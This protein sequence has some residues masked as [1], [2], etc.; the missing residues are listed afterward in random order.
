MAGLEGT[1]K[2]PGA[3][4]VPKKT[5]AIAGGVAAAVVGVGY[6]RKKKAD[7]AA[8]AAA[9]SDGTLTEGT[10]AL[11][12]TSP[13]GPGDLSGGG[14]VTTGGDPVPAPINLQNP[15]IITNSDWQSA[16]AA[17]DLGG[18]DSSTIT[19]AVSKILGG[20]AVTQDQAEIFQEVAGIIGYPPQGYPP[21][22]LVTTTP[23][24]PPP[25]TNPP[26]SK[27]P[28]KITNTYTAH[29]QSMLAVEKIAHPTAGLN[30]LEDYALQ[31]I[32]YNM[33]NGRNHW[34]AGVAG[35]NLINVKFSGPVYVV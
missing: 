28:A 21:I 16:A 8:L 17:M 31:A 1:V 29:N 15:G 13:I 6:Y 24:S 10:D 35:P 4:E 7:A 23:G 2:I 26:P 14:L 3:G 18:V 34:A 22:K 33:S 11:G 25:T 9:T 32:H 30:Q 5:V 19:A 20:V 27:P 12:S